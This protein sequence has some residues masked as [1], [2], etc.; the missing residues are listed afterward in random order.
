MT[1]S[2]KLTTLLA[3][4][5]IG[6][7]AAFVA[8]P[9]V[10]HD[11]A[12]ESPS[13]SEEAAK[14]GSH[15]TDKAER[16]AAR[17]AERVSRKRGHKAFRREMGKTRRMSRHVMRHCEIAPDRLLTTETSPKLNLIKQLID[18]KVA[19]G[20]ISQAE[21]DAVFEYRQTRVTLKT[22]GKMAKYAPMLK[23][24]GVTT[25]KELRD[26]AET[27]GGKRGLMDSKGISKM[28]YRAAKRE[29]MIDRYQVIVDLC[30]SG[31]GMPAEEKP[32]DEEKPSD[33]SP[34]SGESDDDTPKD[35]H[36]ESDDSNSEKSQS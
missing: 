15:D 27:A 13:K 22:A 29:G 11:K 10:A 24:F 14:G 25:R 3:V 5:A 17:R 18:L 2:P 7:G 32:V 19:E 16:R 1:K 36:S 20:D 6:M 34:E 9:A 35:D 28:D 21:A 12:N 26:A 33:V 8:A 31:S 23:L 30:N 4:G